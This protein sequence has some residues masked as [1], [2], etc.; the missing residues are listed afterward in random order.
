MFIEEIFRKQEYK[1]TYFHEATRGPLADRS[2]RRAKVRLRNDYVRKN[3]AS[4]VYI[5][6]FGQDLVRM[7]R[8]IG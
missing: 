2:R 8:A 4:G 7:Q 3:G 6:V 5:T 1:N